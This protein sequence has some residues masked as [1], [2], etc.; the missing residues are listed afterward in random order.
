MKI[1]FTING[2][3]STVKKLKK[4]KAHQKNEISDKNFKKRTRVISSI[5]KTLVNL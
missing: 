3:E 5:A 1:P 4:T 2:T